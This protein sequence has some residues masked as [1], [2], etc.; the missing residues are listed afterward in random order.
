MQKAEYKTVDEYI[1]QFQQEIRDILIQIRQIIKTHAPEAQESISYMMPAYKS[2]GKPLIYFAA[3][4][5]HIGFYA[6]PSGNVAFKKEL[7]SYKQGKGSI[8]FPLNQPIPY[9][10]IAEMVKFKSLENAERA[11]KK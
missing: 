1:E 6:T 3:M 4:K 11:N 10:L 2:H 7:A 8:Q 9:L 5:N